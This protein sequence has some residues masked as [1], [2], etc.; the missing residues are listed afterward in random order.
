MNKHCCGIVINDKVINI[1]LKVYSNQNLLIVTHLNKPGPLL[2]VTRESFQNGFNEN[3]S[4][5][6]IKALFGHVESEVCAAARYIAEH[7]NIDKPLLL[8]LAL[9][10]YKLK[11]LEAVVA[12]L[13]IGPPSSGKTT[14]CNAMSKFLESLGRKVAIINIDPANE[15]ME[16]TPAV[17]IS[18]LVKHEDIMEEYG[19]GPNGALL[20]CMEYLE[21][22]VSWL[23]ARVL[24]LKDHYL[25][26]DCP[27]QVELYTHHKSVSKIVEKLSENLIKL[28]SVHL[29]ESH[30][31][32][33]PGKF[34][35]S[36]LLC[37]TVM[38]RIGLPHV[39][40]MTKFDE[41]KKY[42]EHLPFNIDFYTE[43]LDLKYLLEQLDD[44]PFT[45]RYKKLNAA[46]VSII[47][48]YSL[49]SFIPLDISN[50][51][52]LLKVKNAVDKANGYVFG[53]N[54]PQDVQTLLACAVGATSAT[55]RVSS[56]DEYV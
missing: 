2:L 9:E 18:E 23:I 52:L 46:L 43:V 41:M 12:A 4:V 48:N 28:C 16:Y 47:E 34:L 40:V 32:S 15:N 10:D 37:T 3:N 21:T 51:E 35:S 13:V 49:V 22:H 6:T 8:S 5:F 17:D 36:L 56:L 31:C 39:N 33:D 27:G 19:S 11:T 7:V 38:L 42:S 30:H 53:G 29:V 14:Y 54:E 24:N 44:D 1:V 55:E 20:Y 26:F 25:I 50:E 45:A